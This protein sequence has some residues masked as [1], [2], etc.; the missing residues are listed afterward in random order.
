MNQTESSLCK[1]AL[2]LWESQGLN[3][4]NITKKPPIICEIQLHMT[5]KKPDSWGTGA[6]SLWLRT[7]EA[8]AEKFSSQQPLR[9]LQPSVTPAPRKLPPLGT[10]HVQSMHTGTCSHTCNKTI[11]SLRKN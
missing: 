6:M 8:L 9:G 3:S 1:I 2:S 11:M 10:K 7:Q 4:G 5:L